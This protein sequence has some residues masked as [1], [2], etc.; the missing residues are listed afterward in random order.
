M[1]F[2]AFKFCMSLHNL[3]RLSLSYNRIVL[4]QVYD[5]PDESETGGL[6]FPMA[7]SNL[8]VGCVIEYGRA[9]Q[10]ELTFLQALH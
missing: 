1:F 7:V 5:Q 6:Y 8:F 4:T 3:C 10:L 2:L 9:L